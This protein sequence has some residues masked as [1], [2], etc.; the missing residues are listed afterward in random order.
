MPL[1][2]HATGGCN[3]IAPDLVRCVTPAVHSPNVTRVSIEVSVGGLERTA[4]RHIFEFTADPVVLNV[5]PNHGPMEGGTVL[6]VMG[7]NFDNSNGLFCPLR[8]AD[9]TRSV[10]VR[11]PCTCTT[12][13]VE[14]D[15]L[16]GL[17]QTLST[18]RSP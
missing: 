8:R 15:S 13:A 1:W 10:G 11:F 4:S 2:K 16:R 9:F 6:S 18:L 14:V 7:L 12:P 3:H 17:L 5:F